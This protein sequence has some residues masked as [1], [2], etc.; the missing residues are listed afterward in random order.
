MLLKSLK[1]R[2]S[3]WR[4]L[5][6]VRFGR[7]LSVGEESLRICDSKFEARNQPCLHMRLIPIVAEPS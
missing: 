7:S 4:R 5:R 2:P 6:P 1:N 3:N